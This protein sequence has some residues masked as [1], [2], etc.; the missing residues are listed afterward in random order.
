M[1]PVTICELPEFR[2]AAERFL[3]AREIEAIGDFLAGHPTAG[4]VIRG[5]GGV[6]KLRWALEGTGK[7]GGARTIY[8]YQDDRWPLLLLSI[9]PKGTKQSLTDAECNSMR[10][11]VEAIKAERKM[12]QNER[13]R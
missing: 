11:L 4:A 1:P 2:R 10:H 5:T 8:Y 3:S 9:Y 13:N 12:K 7:S 6:R